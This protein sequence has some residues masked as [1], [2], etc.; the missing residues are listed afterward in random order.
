MSNS[1]KNSPKNKIPDLWD[2]ERRKTDKQGLRNIPLGEKEAQEWI[3]SRKV[4]QHLDLDFLPRHL[5]Y[6]YDGNIAESNLM[7]QKVLEEMKALEEE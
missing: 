2:C 3:K 7:M 5:V 4:D 1:K 6:N